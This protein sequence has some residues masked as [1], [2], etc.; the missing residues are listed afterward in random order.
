MWTEIGLAL[1]AGASGLWSILRAL[2]WQVYAAV[3]VL[4]GCW[5]L[6]AHGVNAG[7]RA[8]RA[9]LAPLLAQAHADAATRLQQAADAEGRAA[10]LEAGLSG[11]IGARATMDTITSAVLTQREQQR[12][13][14]VRALNTTRKELAN[15]YAAS[16]ADACAAQPVPAAVVG[17]L[18]FAAFG[19]AGADTYAVDQDPGAG[20]YPG[21]FDADRAYTG[22]AAPGAYFTAY[23][24]LAAWIAYGWAPA[25]QACNADKASIAGLRAEP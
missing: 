19:Q 8:A 1:K 23:E 6:H 12:A 20:V 13:A 7:D 4:L 24:D 22:A 17:V 10:A 21:A 9:E 2:P 11:C 5:A 18:D 16:S 15:A 14:A 3:A 25:L